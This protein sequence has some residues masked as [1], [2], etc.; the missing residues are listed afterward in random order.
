MKSISLLFI[1]LFFAVSVM[2]QTVIWQNSVA[3]AVSFGYA[4]NIYYSPIAQQ[5]VMTSPYLSVQE[6]VLYLDNWEPKS[7]TNIFTVSIYNDKGDNTIGT[8]VVDLKEGNNYNFSGDPV[9]Y[10][11]N[12]SNCDNQ[13]LPL[14]LTAGNKYW[15]YISCSAQNGIAWYFD[16]TNAVVNGAG[17]STNAYTPMVGYRTNKPFFMKITAGGA[18]S[19]LLENTI[20]DKVRVFVQNKTIQISS[21]LEACNVELI[22]ATGAK[23]MSQSLPAK[24]EIAMNAN[25]PS[26]CYFIKITSAG[27]CFTKKILI[28]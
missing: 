24:G 18:T 13:S 21:D 23:V 19:T 11:I 2:S 10:T 5:F 20:S 1:S 8:K 25:V 15:V 26:G 4:T 14:T 12:S 9:V 3:P 28:R 16:D 17:A 22:T 6:V 27:K 7:T